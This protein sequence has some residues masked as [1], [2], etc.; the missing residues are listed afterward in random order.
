MSACCYLQYVMRGMGCE[1][2]GILWGASVVLKRY[3]SYSLFS[4][5]LIFAKI[6]CSQVAFGC[7]H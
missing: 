6:Y 1:V 7:R 3:Y 4:L 5:I 2:C